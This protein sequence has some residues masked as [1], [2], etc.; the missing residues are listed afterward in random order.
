MDLTAFYLSITFIIKHPHLTSISHF[1]TVSEGYLTLMY[2]NRALIWGR[3][4]LAINYCMIKIN[5]NNNACCCWRWLGWW[6]LIFYWMTLIFLGFL[7]TCPG[8]ILSRPL[9]FSCVSLCVLFRRTDGLR[10]RAFLIRGV[11][12][13]LIGGLARPLIIFEI[14]A[15]ARAAELWLGSLGVDLRFVGQKQVE[16]DLAIVDGIGWDDPGEIFPFVHHIL[17]G[18]NVRTDGL[19]KKCPECFHQLL[20]ISFIVHWPYFIINPSI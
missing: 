14:L 9:G 13:F 7:A 20:L 18:V 5:I 8:M 1:P 11:L 2:T 16:F 4:E 3:R 15:V 19:L 6:L 12:S 17:V 10:V